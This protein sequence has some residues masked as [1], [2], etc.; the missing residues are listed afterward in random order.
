M[1]RDTYE[2]WYH[3]HGSAWDAEVHTC[4]KTEIVGDDMESVRKQFLDENPG[5]TIYSIDVA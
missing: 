4:D 3:M 2:I 1:K 5:A